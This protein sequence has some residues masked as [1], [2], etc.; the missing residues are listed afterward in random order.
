[1]T[2]DD[3]EKIHNKINR[4]LNEEFVAS[5]DYVPQKRDWLSAF[6]AGFKSPSQLSRVR[7]TGYAFIGHLTSNGLFLS[8]NHETQDMCHSA[9]SNPRS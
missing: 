7:N 3:V 9:V 2:K 4:I 1:M 5:K 6:W 8:L